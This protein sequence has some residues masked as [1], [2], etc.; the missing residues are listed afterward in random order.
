MMACPRCGKDS[1]VLET[2]GGIANQVRRRRACTD[3][4]DC[5]MK[6]STVEVVILDKRQMAGPVQLIA[7]RDLRKIE[8][9]ARNALTTGRDTDD[10][11]TDRDR[12]T[13]ATGC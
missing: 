9:L 12:E 13:E 5:G 3:K 1:S 8:R 11:S 6:F 10:V 2:R 7:R 4:Q